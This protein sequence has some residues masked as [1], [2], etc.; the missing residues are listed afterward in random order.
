[1]NLLAFLSAVKSQQSQNIDFE[2]EFAGEEIFPFFY[3]LAIKHLMSSIFDFTDK[4]YELG[5][6]ISFTICILN[7]PKMK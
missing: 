7:L 3:V 1:M 6:C 5:L 2:S 4:S